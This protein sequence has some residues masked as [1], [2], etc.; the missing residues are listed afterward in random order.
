[1]CRKNLWTYC[2][3]GKKFFKMQK[4][5]YDHKRFRHFQE[6]AMGLMESF[7]YS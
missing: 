7:F 4:F 5:D 1:M 2:P 6:E 3:F